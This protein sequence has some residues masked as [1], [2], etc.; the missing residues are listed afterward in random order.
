VIGGILSQGTIGTDRPLAYTSRILNKVE[1]NYSTI[2]KELLAIVYS[3]NHFQPYQYGLQFTL[4]TD[5]QPLR[6]V[7]SV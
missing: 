3:I 1:Q 6:W 7:H 4:M 2:E 5:Y